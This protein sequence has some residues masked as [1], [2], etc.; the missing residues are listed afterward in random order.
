LIFNE[1]NTAK[2]TLFASISRI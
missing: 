2:C 1:C